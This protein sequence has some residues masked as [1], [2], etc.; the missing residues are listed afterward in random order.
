MAR[1]RN[2]FPVRT[3]GVREQMAQV[4]LRW[5]HLVCR[6]RNGMLVCDGAVRPTPM[7]QSYT[8]RLEYRVGWQPRVWVTSP[9]L[10][11]HGS[12]PNQPIPHTYHST[13]QG[14]ERPCLF[15]PNSG[16]WRSDK[17]LAAT[18][19]PWVYEWLVFYELWHITGEWLGGGIEHGQGSDK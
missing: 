19:I 12:A 13:R 1:R 2:P 5:P 14:R 10:K 17:S 16:G 8:V 4:R 9:R 18:V 3:I 11:R 15:F 7:S 6:I